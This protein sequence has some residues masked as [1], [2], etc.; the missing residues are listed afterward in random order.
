MLP[1]AAHKLVRADLIHLRAL[2]Q[3]MVNRVGRGESFEE[4]DEQ[5]HRALLAP[6]GNAALDAILQTFWA[7]FRASH[8]DDDNVTEDPHIAAMH[9]RVVDAI[10][11][12]DIR[13]AVHELDAHFYGVRNRFPDV[14]F[15]SAS[16]FAT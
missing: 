2:A 4:L 15:G 3:E 1:A 16:T 13:L 5:F 6:L 12:G 14:T 10:E 8:S 9:E 7:V 11:V